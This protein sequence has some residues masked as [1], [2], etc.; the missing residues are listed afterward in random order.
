MEK[1][2]AKY[3]WNVIADYSENVQCSYNLVSRD[4]D[5]IALEYLSELI[6]RVYKEAYLDG[7]RDAL[8]YTDM[9]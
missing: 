4:M 2:K 7:L 8:F 1:P 5:K 3:D 6:D 9:L